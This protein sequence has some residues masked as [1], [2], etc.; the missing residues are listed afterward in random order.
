[1]R[2][3]RLTLALDTGAI[4]LPE[5]GRI[6]VFRPHAGD[7][8]SV[9]PKDRVSIIQG[10]RPDHDAFAAAGYDVAVSATGEAAAALVCLPRSKAEGRALVAEAAARV[11]PGGPVI[12]DGQKTDGIDAMLRDIRA[13]V[14][15][16]MPVAK[17]HGRIFSFAASPD[18][19]DWAGV[20]TVTEDGFVTLP[21]VSRALDLFTPCQSLL[22]YLS[23]SFHCHNEWSIFC[24]NGSLLANIINTLCRNL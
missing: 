6:H 15:T 11:V 5:T 2:S 23:N 20:E 3:S 1:M 17:A 7:D 19:K 16:S 12:V 14:E 8:L 4:S 10:F 24:E 18:F 9:F 21:G 13:R 22:L